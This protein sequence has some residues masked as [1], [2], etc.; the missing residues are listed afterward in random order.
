[1]SE[2]TSG[3]RLVDSYSDGMCGWVQYTDGCRT[4]KVHWSVTSP[5]NSQ[6]A[7]MDEALRRLAVGST[8]VAH[9]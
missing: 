3:P 7:A 9:G 6:H 4:E 1:M 8:E 5:I 2:P